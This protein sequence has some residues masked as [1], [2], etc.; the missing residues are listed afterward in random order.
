MN[1]FDRLMDNFFGFMLVFLVGIGTF[2]TI[3]I[4]IIAYLFGPII[5]REN[6]TALGYEY[7][8]GFWTSCYVN[9]KDGW[10][11]LEWQQQKV[12]KL[13]QEQP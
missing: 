9:T 12:I 7:R 8:W 11:P 5:C 6:A 4:L 13:R 3:I 1:F 10:Q 2:C